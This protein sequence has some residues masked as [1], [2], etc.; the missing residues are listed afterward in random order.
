MPAGTVVDKTGIERLR[1]GDEVVVLALRG[2]NL[3]SWAVSLVRRAG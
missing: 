2:A 1:V 3:Q